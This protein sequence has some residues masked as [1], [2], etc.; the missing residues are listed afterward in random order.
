MLLSVLQNAAHEARASTT[1]NVEISMK[2]LSEAQTLA[3]ELVNA[4]NINI[5]DFKMSLVYSI[6]F[7]HNQSFKLKLA[8][9]LTIKNV[10]DVEPEQ[11]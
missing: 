7:K 5:S 3:V 11:T 2:P 8:D 9:D 10:L 4:E 1:I 6:T